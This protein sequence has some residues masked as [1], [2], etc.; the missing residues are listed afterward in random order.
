MFLKLLQDHEFEETAT[1]LL[2]E[3][4]RYMALNFI[5][6]LIDQIKHQINILENTLLILMKENFDF[7]HYILQRIFFNYTTYD[8]PTIQNVYNTFIACVPLPQ[9]V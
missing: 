3:I 5:I 4:L 8:H 7:S 6:D 1:D 2:I 9:A